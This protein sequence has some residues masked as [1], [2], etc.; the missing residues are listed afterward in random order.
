MSFAIGSTH[1]GL[2]ALT[3]MSIPAPQST[4]RP[5]ST[6]VRLGDGSV[7]GMGFPVA[8]WHWGF[9][10]A[11]QRDQLR[12][13]CPGQSA[14]VYIRTVKDD[15]TYDD[16]SAVMVWPSEEERAAGR[17]LDFTLEFHRLVEA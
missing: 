9:L 13:L 12:A 11:A 15:L 8:T 4:Y 5:T 3:V 17:V 2:Q 16:F 6:D 14:A 10:S 7:R 1:A